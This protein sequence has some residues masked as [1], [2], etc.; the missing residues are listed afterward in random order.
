MIISDASSDEDD[1][2]C[3]E[4]FD[5]RRSYHFTI[6]DPEC[7]LANQ[8]HRKIFRNR[9]QIQN[10]YS[11]KNDHMKSNSPK[12]QCVKR[13]LDNVKKNNLQLRRITS[14]HSV[15]YSLP[16]QKHNSQSHRITSVKEGN[17]THTLQSNTQE[18]TLCVKNKVLTE[19]ITQTDTPQKANQG[20]TSFMKDSSVSPEM[21]Y[22]RKLEIQ[23]QKREIEYL[24]AILEDDVSTT[25]LN[26]LC[27]YKENDVE[28]QLLLNMN[29]LPTGKDKEIES[30][31]VL[32]LLPSNEDPVL[33]FFPTEEKSSSEIICATTPPAVDLTLLRSSPEIRK[34][35]TPVS[36]QDTGINFSISPIMYSRRLGKT[37][38]VSA[39]QF[40]IHRKNSHSLPSPA[41]ENI[42][43]D[44]YKKP[45]REKKKM[46]NSAEMGFPNP[47]GTNKC[48][49]N[50]SLQV[51]FGM[52]PFIEDLVNVFEKSNIVESK[53]KYSSLLE[54]FIEV[55]KARQTR[56]QS[57]L[58]KNLEFLDKTLGVLNEHFTTHSQEDAVEFLT[59]FLTALREEFYRLMCSNE[60][61]V[62]LKDSCRQEQNSNNASDMN[63]CPKGE[64]SMHIQLQNPVSENII[65][66]LK[67]IQSCMMCSKQESKET[68]HLTLIV[69]IP[70]ET[71]REITLQEALESCMMTEIRELKCA[72]CESEQCRVKTVFTLLPR[73]LVLH[74]N[75]FEMQNNVIK[76]LCKYLKIPI[77]L[78]VRN[79]ISES[80]MMMPRQ[81]MSA[82]NKSGNS[83][84]T[85]GILDPTILNLSPS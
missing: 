4:K 5:K 19:R 80:E 48:W 79:V 66:K 8:M 37:S 18:Q 35:S 17:H 1:T 44:K 21:T 45:L 39:Y 13:P 60:V 73:F 68:E 55:V 51:V 32:L 11:Q 71:L 40:E 24:R 33:P 9:K 82:N 78:T 2:L 70:S 15:K 29:Q 81:W 69:N 62:A 31:E 43:S 53:G 34:T 6:Y 59:E 56:N 85:A 63:T 26:S 27:T 57:Q 67:E 30:R 12:K 83:F 42:Q 72:Q 46:K 58:N 52:K 77:T 16:F 54:T 23:N 74:V 47:I 50:S 20:R 84:V 14:R 22:V 3:E 76:K 75:R 64:S 41:V 38:S 28:V 7:E 65:F 49:M 25:D 61:Y 36:S 10:S